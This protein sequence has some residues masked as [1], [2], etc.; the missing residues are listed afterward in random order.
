M[1]RYARTTERRP[2]FYQLIYVPAVT[3]CLGLAF[4]LC[5][6]RYVKMGAHHTL[7]M[8]LHRAFSI[9]KDDWDMISLD[10]IDTACDQTKKADAAAVV[11]EPGLA[12]VCLYVC[13][14]LFTGEKEM[15]RIPLFAYC[16]TC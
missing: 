7:E 3:R 15:P 1:H 12:H 8:E 14:Y 16:Q 10:R 2:T 4:L 13:L 11:L 9:E 5:P 6:K